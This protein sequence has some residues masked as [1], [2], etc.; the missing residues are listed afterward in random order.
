[1]YLTMSVPARA[2]HGEGQGLSEA[3]KVGEL[4]NEHFEAGHELEHAALDFVVGHIGMLREMAEDGCE[5][6]ADLIEAVDLYFE[7][8][9]AMDQAHTDTEFAAIVS[10]IE[11]TA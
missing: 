6:A 7:T 11:A 10:Q 4:E 5:G 9:E 3:E 2:D 1:M 8:F